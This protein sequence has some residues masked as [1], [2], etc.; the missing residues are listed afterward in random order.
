VLEHAF[1][2]LSW[3]VNDDDA[4]REPHPDWVAFLDAYEPEPFRALGAPS[5]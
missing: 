2:H 3:L 5:S 4:V 1:R